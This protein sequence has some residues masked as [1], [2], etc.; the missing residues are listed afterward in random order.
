[1]GNYVSSGRAGILRINNYHC[2]KC[3]L[4]NELPN[5]A[6]RFFIVNEHECQ[7][8][9]CGTI[10][11]KTIMYKPVSITTELPEENFRTIPYAMETVFTPLDASPEPDLSQSVDGDGEADA[12]ETLLYPE[13]IYP[14]FAEVSILQT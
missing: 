10:Y 6:G 2:P 3:R 5:A 7:C 8:N 12:E 1:M 13:I 9:G 11:D 14:T 4:T